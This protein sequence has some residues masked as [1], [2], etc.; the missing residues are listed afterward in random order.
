MWI[1]MIFV[2]FFLYR[3]LCVFV[4]KKAILFL[5]GVSF[6]REVM[7]ESD[8]DPAPIDNRSIIVL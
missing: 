8:E 6:K 5:I 2:I 3:K 7:N 4:K 1:N